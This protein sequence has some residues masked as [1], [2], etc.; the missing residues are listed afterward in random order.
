MDFCIKERGE[1]LKRNLN[2]HCLKIEKV[3][4]QASFRGMSCWTPRHSVLSVNEKDIGFEVPSETGQANLAPPMIP[5]VCY[6]SVPWVPLSLRPTTAS[7]GWK[8]KSKEE[9]N[10][11][12]QLWKIEGVRAKLIWSESLRPGKNKNKKTKKGNQKP[13]PKAST[14]KSKR[15]KALYTL[16]H[17]LLP[18]GG[19][20]KKT[21]GNILQSQ[22]PGLQSRVTLEQAGA[23][24]EYLWAIG[25]Q[26]WFFRGK[27]LLP[28]PHS[29]GG[30]CL[31]C[32]PESSCFGSVPHRV[33]W[34]MLGCPCRSA[35]FSNFLRAFLLW[36]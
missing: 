8:V 18:R 1:T 19:R 9:E 28:S 2:T 27:R 24:H 23:A 4:A 22:A 17:P 14:W 34:K 15:Q 21:L 20:E 29:L 16:S 33:C 10:K 26:I 32:S 3:T 5:R 36:N 6:I 30:S 11:S 13:R 12:C 25:I 31:F 35:L 7:R